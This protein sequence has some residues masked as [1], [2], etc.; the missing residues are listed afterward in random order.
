MKT[1]EILLLAAAGAAFY[2]SWRAY[3]GAALLVTEK[4]NP[5][6]SNN[7]INENIVNAI[8]RRVTDDEHFTLGGFLFEVFNP[9][10][11]R[12]D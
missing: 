2:L 10:A 4:L 8:G 9:N 6:S 3:Q 1:D 7:F 11:G 12:L 5:A